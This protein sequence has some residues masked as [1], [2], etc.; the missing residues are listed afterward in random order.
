MGDPD[1]VGVN[2]PGHRPDFIGVNAAVDTRRP[3]IYLDTGAAGNVSRAF[4]IFA[5]RF[6]Q[7][8]GTRGKYLSKTPGKGHFSFGHQPA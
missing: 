3:L 8:N 5:L 2:I 6:H 7:R 4:P 1:P